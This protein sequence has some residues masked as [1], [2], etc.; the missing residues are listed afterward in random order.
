M[1]PWSRV[2]ASGLGFREML[3]VCYAWTLGLG[4]NR[5]LLQ[6][7]LF[8]CLVL[9]AYTPHLI[10]V[11]VYAPHLIPES[12]LAAAPHISTLAHSLHTLYFL[13]LCTSST[14]NSQHSTLTLDSNRCTP[15]VTQSGCVHTQVCAFQPCCF[16]PLGH[17]R[18]HVVHHLAGP[19]TL[20]PK[21]STCNPKP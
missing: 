5:D 10:F 6:H 16:S 1:G 19:Q 3:L 17:R 9:F 20:N 13:S 21:P 14:L 2:L 15:T 4:L 11:L 8:V 7:R 12:C 18:R